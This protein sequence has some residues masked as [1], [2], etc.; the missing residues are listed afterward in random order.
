MKIFLNKFGT[1][2]T[3]YDDGCEAFAAFQPTLAKLSDT[4]KI[5]IDFDGVL[6][7]SPSWADEFLG[8]LQRTYPKRVTY[9][10]SGNPSVQATLEFLKQLPS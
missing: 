8:A 4:E 7:L 6:T 10:K 9:K 3:S 2:L 1:V 5:T